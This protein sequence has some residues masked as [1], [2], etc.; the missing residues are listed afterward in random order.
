MKNIEDLNLEGTEEEKAPLSD[1]EI[2]LSDK[3][4][5]NIKKI[6]SLFNLTEKWVDI[7]KRALFYVASQK[8]SS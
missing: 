2:K 5:N 4:E 3:I 6:E 1:F 7:L 8:S